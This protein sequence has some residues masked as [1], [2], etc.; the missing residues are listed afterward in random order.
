MLNRRT[1]LAAA[2]AAPAA[3]LFA[4]PALAAK[5][6]VFIHGGV[7]IRG[8][9]PVA[10][11]TE[12]APVIGSADHALEWEGATWNFASAQNMETFMGNPAAYAPQ[13]GGYCAFALSR[14]SI[15]TSVPEAWSIVDDKLYLNY[16]VNVRQVWSEDI[17]G[18]I[19]KAD[20][21]WPGVLA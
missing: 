19:A 10:F 9:D 15:A 5:P 3:A 14:G 4:R 7:A 20:A 2:A 6:S 8:A 11:F 12:G 16:S 21:N 13:Y 18:N 17:P 1:L